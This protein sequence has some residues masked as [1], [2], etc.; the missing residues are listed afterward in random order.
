[1]VFLHREDEI[2]RLAGRVDYIQGAHLYRGSNEYLCSRGIYG[3]V[4]TIMAYCRNVSIHLD[5]MM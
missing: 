3:G 5:T 2:V 1:M 4:Y